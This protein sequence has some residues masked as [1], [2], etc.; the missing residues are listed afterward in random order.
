MR[1][2]RGPGGRFL[3][4][5]EI[6]AQKPAQPNESPTGETPVEQEPFEFG[7]EPPR[8]AIPTS[9]EYPLQQYEQQTPV[10]P[11]SALMEVSSYHSMSHPSTPLSATSQTPFQSKEPY[12]RMHHVPHPHAHARARNLNFNDML[13]SQ[14]NTQYPPQDGSSVHSA[15]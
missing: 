13:Y 3:T 4:A 1:R 15:S 9:T 6:A 14:D 11:S 12:P 8:L 7:E 10:D 2:P 5:E